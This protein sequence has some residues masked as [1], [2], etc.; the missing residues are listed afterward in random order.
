M[1]VL[2][3]FLG[4]LTRLTDSGLSIIEWKPVSGVIPPLNDDDWQYE[5][6]KYQQSPEYQKKNSNMT[7]SEFKFIFW[8]EFIHRLAGRVAGLLYLLPLLYFAINGK[9]AKKSY[10]SYFAILLLFAIQGFMGWYMVKSG[11]VLEPYVSHFR[12]ACHLII[13]VM[14]YNLLF[15]K[16][17]SNN[18]DILLIDKKIN[19]KWQQAFCLLS[20]IVIY[21]QIFLGGLVAGLDAG[22]V[23]N[24]FP[25]MDNNFIAEEIQ[26]KQLNIDSF[27]DPVFIQF[28]HRINAYIICFSVILFAI[29]LRKI[30]HPKLNKIAY[31]AFMALVLQMLTGII[32][33]LYSVPIIIALLHQFLAII[34]LSSIL[35]GYFLLKS[36]SW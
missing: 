10:P 21:L 28:I 11:L 4:G 12:L 25:L 36:A 17:M 33:L 30:N 7:V 29:N 23:Y 26:F 5:F 24:N 1:V 8:L 27:S 14:I 19:L 31:Y 15:Y 2:I 34:L 13:A 9:I 16:L 35:W 20:I 32:T 3:I 22:L 18:F 6:T